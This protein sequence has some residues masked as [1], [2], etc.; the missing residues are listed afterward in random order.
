MIEHMEKEGK[1]EKTADYNVYRIGNTCHEGRRKE[2]A[3]IIP[4]GLARS[5]YSL[6]KSKVP[7]TY[8]T[9]FSVHY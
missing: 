2:Y 7:L 6:F 3:I 1:I 9:R 8:P 4:I 5:P